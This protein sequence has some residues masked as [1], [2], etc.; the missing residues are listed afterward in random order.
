MG[1]VLWNSLGGEFH[2]P[3]AILAAGTDE[4]NAIFRLLFTILRRAGG[5]HK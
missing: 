5:K 3:G 1:S 4:D 2:I